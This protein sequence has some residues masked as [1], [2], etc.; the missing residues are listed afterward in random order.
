MPMS[1]VRVNVLF[2]V[3]YALFAKIVRAAIPL[4]NACKTTAKRQYLV[5]FADT[6][7]VAGRDWDRPLGSLAEK[8]IAR[9]AYKPDFVPGVAPLR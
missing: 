8:I 4:A 9:M 6:S 2:P 5:P 7:V 1:A 3:F